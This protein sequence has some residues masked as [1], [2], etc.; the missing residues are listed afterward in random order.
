MQWGLGR[1][2]ND[3]ALRG[4]LRA[5]M[6]G[7]GETF[8][9]VQAVGP[10]WGYTTLGDWVA[11]VQPGL[12]VG[13]VVSSSGVFYTGHLRDESNALPEIDMLNPISNRSSGDGETMVLTLPAGSHDDT[14]PL[15]HQASTDSSNTPNDASINRITQNCNAAL[16]SNVEK[17]ISSDSTSSE[18]EDEAA[19]TSTVLCRAV[20]PL[21]C[22]PKPPDDWWLTID[23][24]KRFGG[25][26]PDGG[27]VPL[28][29]PQGGARQKKNTF[30]RRKGYRLAAWVPLLL[31]VPAIAFILAI[32][33]SLG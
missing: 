11:I 8:W 5:V 23:H 14:P 1:I 16:G 12:R 26:V 32:N 4:I 21:P 33:W 29:C 31:L 25:D 28:F 17:K 15:T 19:M 13:A 24:M 18:N 3:P 27:C 20:N 10:A 30:G 2:A 22:V 6:K 9:R 7:R